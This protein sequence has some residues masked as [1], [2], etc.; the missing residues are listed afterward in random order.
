MRLSFYENDEE[1]D[2]CYDF[3]MVLAIY[4][5]CLAPILLC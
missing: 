3:Y 2:D 1:D 4:V 5:L